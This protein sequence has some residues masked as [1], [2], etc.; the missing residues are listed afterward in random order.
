MGELVVKVLRVCYPP[1]TEKDA[2]WF[3]LQTSAGTAKGNLSWRPHDN[4]DL[5]L[6]GEWSTYRGSREY[7]FDGGKLNIPADPRS[8]LRYCC[9]RTT[10]MG[11][12]TE[13][14]IWTHSGINWK[15]IQPGAVPRLGGALFERF[16]LSI[17]SLAQNQAQAEVTGALMV[18]GCTPLQAQKAW[19]TW[20]DS[21]LGVVQADPFR[22]AELERVSFSDVDTKIRQAYGIADNDMRRIKAAVVHSLRMLTDNG[23]TVVEWADLYAAACGAL[24]GYEELVSDATAEL[25]KS[26]ALKAFSE[27]KCVALSSDFKAESDI[28]DYVN[29]KGG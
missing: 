3:I 24:G 22:L 29:Q 7:K 6:F 8:L 21:A 18:K 2:A 13:D 11:T 5:I 23:S 28:W 1:A 26:G 12:I 27:S 19:D 25:F 14:A 4:E 17:E 15:T 10:G 16:K 20:K 9:E